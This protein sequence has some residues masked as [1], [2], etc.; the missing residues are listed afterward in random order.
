MNQIKNQ[1][2]RETSRFYMQ[3]YTVL[4]K[5]G[6]TKIG[7]KKR[8]K[9]KLLSCVLFIFLYQIEYFFRK[10]H[11]GK[12]QTILVIKYCVAKQN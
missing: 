11:F 3:C 9:S 1:I 10:V 4:Q 8:T 12:L 5:C 2:F 6:H 7:R